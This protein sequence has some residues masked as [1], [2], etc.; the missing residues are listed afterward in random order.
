MK[1]ETGRLLFHPITLADLNPLTVL[2]S[3]CAVMRYLPT[4]QP[5]SSRDTRKILEGFVQH[6]QEK[7]FGPWALTLKENKKFIGYC[8]L[9][10]AANAPEIEL[11][12]GIARAFWGMGIAG[13]AAGAVLKWGFESIGLEKITAAVLPENIASKRILEG[14]G[15][16]SDPSLDFYGPDVLYY[17][18]SRANYLSKISPV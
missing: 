7:K 9:L 13:E 6:W 3:D 5:R 8:G 15:M 18:L 12:Y 11:L 1:L 17:S 10:T 16:E 2:W 4:G 14:L